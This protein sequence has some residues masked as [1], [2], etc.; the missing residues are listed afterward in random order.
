MFKI[1]R[2]A[3]GSVVVV[4]GVASGAAHAANIAGHRAFYEMRMGQ[5]N[6]NAVVQSVSGRSAFILERDCD[7]WR[8]AEDYMIEFGNGDGR[9][10]RIISHFESWESEAGDQYSFDI[11]EQSSFQDDKDF[12]GYAE[13]DDD[14]GKAVFLLDAESNITL[15]KNTY[16]PMQH[17]RAIINKAGDGGKILAASVFTGAEPNDALLTT[18]TVIGGW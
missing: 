17:I 13:I 10:D 8:S 7:G 4:L 5:A 9:V 3:V 16:F 15:P 1:T 11:A 14:G 2:Y 18:N 12:G 6:K